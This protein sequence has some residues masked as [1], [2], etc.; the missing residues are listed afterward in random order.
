MSKLP[1]VAGLDIGTNSIKVLVATKKPDSSNFQVL[2]QIKKRSFGIRRGVVDDSESVSKIIRAIID[3][4]NQ[5]V[6]REIEFV[7]TNINGSHIFSRTS[8]G[9]ISVSRADA[10]ISQED[11]DRVIQ[12][13]QTF[14]LGP[15]HDVFDCYPKEFIIDGEG[16]IKD[17]VGLKGVRLEVDIMALGGFSPYIKNL[18]QAVSG[19]GLKLVDYVTSPI[20][21][22]IA[23]LTPRQK[24]L[25][26]ALLDIGAGTSS[27]VVFEE[28]KLLSIKIF[29]IGSD[30]I[31][32]DIN[33]GLQ[34]DVE[35]AEMIKK[36]YGSCIKARSTKKDKIDLEDGIVFTRKNLTRII[37]A[38]VSEI[39]ELVKK[40]LKAI[41]KDKG[42]PAGLVITGGGSKMTG[43]LELA[44]KELSLPVTVAGPNNFT[45]LEDSLNWSTACGLVIKGFENL[46][47]SDISP[48]GGKVK[49]LFKKI[50]KIFIP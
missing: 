3:E 21:S 17:P 47:E 49:G 41:H 4:T 1:I 29:P 22:A 20:A 33:I 19:A 15:N 42:L 6:G 8:H 32:Y 2:S 25:G 27:L 9:L 35:T 37:E 46:E 44:K 5:Q 50:F 38:R 11:K 45:S 7:Y 36:E 28:G 43:I 16:G 34:T 10:K 31:T 14:S 40:E 26:V 13:A 24:E 12:E 39:L 48:R 18:E 23:V 30:H